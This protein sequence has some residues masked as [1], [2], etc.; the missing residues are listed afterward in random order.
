MLVGWIVEKIQNEEQFLASSLFPLHHFASPE[1]NFFKGPW[2][3]GNDVE[4][5]TGEDYTVERAD[6]QKS[7]DLLAWAAV[8]K[9]NFQT[10]VF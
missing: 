10:S 5:G 6:W 3:Y 2:V 1:N 4:C 9:E 8:G 7:A